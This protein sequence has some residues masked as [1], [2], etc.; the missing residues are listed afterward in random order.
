M[1]HSGATNGNIDV[2]KTIDDSI[3]CCLDGLAIYNVRNQWQKGI[4]VRFG[5]IPSRC[6]D[7]Q[8][9]DPA[10]PLDKSLRAGLP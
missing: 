6:G 8:S 1:K 3:M 5:R 9:N 2:A 7:I 4:G 10:P